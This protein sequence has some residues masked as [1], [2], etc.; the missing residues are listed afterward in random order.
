MLKKWLILKLMTLQSDEQTIT[1]Q[2]L[3]NIS[4]RQGNRTMKLA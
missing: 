3:S 4:Q 2:I 1:A